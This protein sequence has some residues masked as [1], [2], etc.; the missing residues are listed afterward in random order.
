M[1]LR[2]SKSAHSTSYTVIKSA[3]I[4]KV[5]TTVTVEYLGNDEQIRQKYHVDDAEAWARAHVDE[6]NRLAKDEKASASIT[7][8]P[9]AQL[10]M[11]EQRSFNLGYLFLQRIFYQLGLNKICSTIKQ[12]HSFDYNLTSILSRLLYTRILYPGSKLSSF[13]DSQKFVEA[14][15]FD[16]HQIYRALS[17]LAS[18][19]D[20]IQQ[21]LYKNSLTFSKRNTSVIYYDC[22]NYYFEIEDADQPGGLRQY[23]P[24]KEHRPNPITQMGLF[25]DSEGI[26]LAFSINPG[27]INEQLTLKPLEKKLISDF[28]LSKMVVCT[29]AGLSSMDNRLYNTLNGRAF[30][31]VQSI[32]TLKAFQKEWCLATDEWKLLNDDSSKTYDLTQLDHDNDYEKIFYKERWFNENGLEQRFIVTYSLKYKD[33]LASVRKRQLDRAIKKMNAPG[34]IDH[35]RQ[36]DPNRFIEQLHFTADGE[37]AE[38]KAYTLDENRFAEESQ[39]DGFYAVATNLTDEASSIVKVNQRRWEIEECFRIMKHEFVAR[40]CFLSREDRIKAHFMTCFLALIIFRYLEKQLGEGFTIENII[41]TLRNMNAVK[42]EGKGY[43]PTYT[44]TA[45]T[46]LL[47]STSGFNTSTEII[48]IAKMR[49]IC[50][51]TKQSKSRKNG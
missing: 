23:G 15:D 48:S 4:N 38:A 13:N 36:N 22:T 37:V 27:N 47:H 7:F 2:V 25:M 35:F 17:L 18:E 1:R 42:I 14:P 6:L 32:K 19:S 50:K 12:R 30:I 33:Y 45:L 16:L 29:D 21:S 26:P 51:Q 43:I 34:S 11:D 9:S 39:Y 3:Y 24:S 40:P 49:N 10:A 28:S 20:F 8:S 44:R 46:D 41:S 31:T 5:R